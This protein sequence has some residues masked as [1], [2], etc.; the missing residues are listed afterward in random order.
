R[1]R[2][3]A[4]RVASDVA[5]RRASAML[6]ISSVIPTTVDTPSSPVIHNVLDGG[7]EEA[8]AASTSRQSPW[9]GHVVSIGS[10][11]SYRNV[12]G[13]IAGYHRY[14]D[15]G[16]QAP[17]IVAGPAG[18]PAAVADAREAARGL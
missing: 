11:H 17:L 1:L 16:G 13:L 15:A 18:S 12:P 8:L 7:F 6:R 3:T 4:L 2:A 5:L 10:L 9:Q 14:R